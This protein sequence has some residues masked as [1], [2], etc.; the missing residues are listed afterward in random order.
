MAPSRRPPRGDRVQTVR[1]LRDRPVGFSGSRTLTP[2]QQLAI[3]AE[4]IALADRPN[5]PSIVTGGC[6]GVDAYVAHVAHNQGLHVHTIVP[7]NRRL[8]DPSWRE[9]C[10]S[11]E[12][13]PLGTTYRDRNVR[14]VLRSSRLVA[15]PSFDASSV[16]SHHSGTWMTIRLARQHLLPV[17]L[18][19][20]TNEQRSPAECFPPGVFLAEELAA[21]GWTRR[22]AVRH[23]DWEP[24]VLTRVIKGRH[25]IDQDLADGLARALGTSA[26][27]WLNLQA[28]YTAYQG[29]HDVPESDDASA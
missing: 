15:L 22:Q 3:R 13:M 25:T 11:Y 8:V 26:E 24:H 7:A 18:L 4:L 6:V 27:Y 1:T 14:L 19:L 21:R 17:T 9:H 12:E 10:S 5:P 2:W 28:A 20:A 29:D 16:H 23:L